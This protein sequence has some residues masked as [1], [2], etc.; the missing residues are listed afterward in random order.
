MELIGDRLASHPLHV[1]VPSSLRSRGINMTVLESP[2]KEFILHVDEVVA[3]KRASATSSKVEY[4]D[5]IKE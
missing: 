5:P 1:G 3:K 2:P 4:P